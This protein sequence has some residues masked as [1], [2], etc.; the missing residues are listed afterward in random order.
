MEI[1]QR[2]LLVCGNPGIGKTSLLLALARGFFPPSESVPKR[3]EVSF[4]LVEKKAQRQKCL[5]CILL[6]QGWSVTVSLN[7]N[8]VGSSSTAGKTASPALKRTSSGNA[9]SSS[10]VRILIS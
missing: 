10:L 5:N 1:R 7:D 2:N 6:V 8:D 4:L 3:F 9:A